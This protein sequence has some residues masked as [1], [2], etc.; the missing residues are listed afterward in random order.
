MWSS[1]NRDSEIFVD[2]VPVCDIILVP[3]LCLTLLFALPQLLL[4]WCNS[5]EISIYFKNTP[6]QICK[7]NWIIGKHWKIFDYW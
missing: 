1:V 5:D 2:E 6:L 4:Q 3:Y 7:H